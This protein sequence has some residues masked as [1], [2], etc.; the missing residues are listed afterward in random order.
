[1]NKYN[2]RLEYID[3]AK[4]LLII[5]IVRGHISYAFL[6][7]Y[8]LEDSFYRIFHVSAFFVIGGFFLKE[9]SLIKPIDIIR[10]KGKTLYVKAT[11]YFLVATLLHNLWVTTG[12]YQEHYS[13]PLFQKYD[14][15]SEWSIAVLRVVC[16]ISSEPIVQ[17]TWFALT[18]F[19]AIVLLSILV[20]LLHRIK[21]N[22]YK[23]LFLISFALSVCACLLSQHDVRI[24]PERIMSS[25]SAIVLVCFGWW[26]WNVAGSDRFSSW[27][28]FIGC[29]FGLIGITYTSGREPYFMAL[30]S[31]RYHDP[32]TYC[33]GGILGT[34]FVCFIARKLST[35]FIGKMMATCGRK[36]FEIMALH[37][38]YMRVL[39]LLS[40]NWVVYDT[41]SWQ[42]KTNFVGF[43]I[44]F[45]G[46][47]CLSLITSYLFDMI[48]IRKI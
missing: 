43:T 16:G 44:L 32:L 48:K 3:I 23:T 36:S 21:R 34:Y 18:L 31:N 13:S 19:Y 1:M 12:I 35:N 15:I 20:Y 27:Y 46:S 17:P 10:K 47:I 41:T 45:L 4:G 37:I 8:F 6:P 29:I 39:I 26:Y 9:S 40:N 24:A 30:I 42:V 2:N 22:D 25:Y 7:D 38:F 5:L 33:I 14:S 11:L 28:I